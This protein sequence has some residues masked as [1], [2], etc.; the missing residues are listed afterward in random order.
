MSGYASSSDEPAAGRRRGVGTRSDRRRSRLLRAVPVLLLLIPAPLRAQTRVETSVGALAGIP[1]GGFARSLPAACPGITLSAGLRFRDSPLLVGGEFGFLIYGHDRRSDP[2][3][4]SRPDLMVPRSVW[5]TIMQA[6]FFAR[7][8]FGADPIN[9][10]LE[11]LGGISS[12]RTDSTVERAALAE[13]Y[14]GIQSILH[15]E[16]APS[17]GVGA[18]VAILL[19]RERAPEP[20]PRRGEPRGERRRILL[21]IGGR[22]LAGGTAAYLLA[23]S[24]RIEDGETVY[25]LLRSGTSRLSVTIGLR[26][27]L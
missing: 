19:R 16:A 25:D 14:P 4:S 9:P 11:V 18:G 15:T 20:D 10:F 7:W 13:D 6:H 21:E 2:L 27:I 8:T 5:N 17:A 22:F 1:T 26:W 23:E 3:S 12:L 24:I